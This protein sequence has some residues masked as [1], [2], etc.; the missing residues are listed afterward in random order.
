MGKPEMKWKSINIFLVA[1][2]LFSA[3]ISCVKT[4]ENKDVSPAL[5]DL[6][7]HPLY[8]E[9]Q[10]D[11]S[12]NVINLGTQ[13]LYMPTGLITETM[14]RDRILRNALKKLG[15]EIR[16]YP[17]LK[18]HDVNYFLKKGDL[19]AG[20]GGDMPTISI[21]ATSEVIIPSLIQQGF[22][23]IV[24]NQHMLIKDMR[25]YR[26]GYAYGS[27]AHYA[28]LNALS[29]RGIDET[30]VK[31]IPI[32]V[33][34]MPEALKAGKIDAF[35]AWEPTPF[36][37]TKKYPDKIVIHR[38]MSTGYFYLSRS[39]YEKHPDAVRHILAA[40]IRAFQWMRHSKKNLINASQW[41]LGECN[42]LSEGI[43]ALSDIEIS[44]LAT[45]DIMG[46]TLTPVIPPSFISRTGLL[47]KEFKFLK[48]LGKIPPSTTWENIYDSFDLQILEDV[49][50]DPSGYRFDEFDYDRDGED[51]E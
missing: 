15:M 30:D 46:H 7:K 12:D 4:E 8:S 43:S 11:S 48:E 34:E 22:V 39:L 32:N 19:D 49:T 26:I 17:F 16:F 18:G 10:F 13:P 5:T 42:K 44:K 31:L 23:S 51:S 50:D 2:L 36:L 14:K 47:Y 3:L 45:D 38:S 28:L 20:I 29:S 24:A 35:S 37:T 27:N 6:S 40:E 21:A 9:Y 1:V 33:F 41:N 25:G